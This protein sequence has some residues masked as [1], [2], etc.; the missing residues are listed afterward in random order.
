MWKKLKMSYLTY[1][2]AELVI[3]LVE[4]SDFSIVDIQ[5]ICFKV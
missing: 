1:S 3:A 4:S 2:C 5:K